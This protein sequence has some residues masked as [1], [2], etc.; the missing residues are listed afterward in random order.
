MSGP[1]LTDRLDRLLAGDRRALARVLT[2][3]EDGSP[4][5]LREI[6][7]AVHP[8]SGRARLIG[9]TGPPGVGKSTLVARLV[10][11]WRATGVRVAVLAVDPSS[12]FSGGALLGDRVRMQEHALDEGVFLRSMANRGHL[13][14]LAVAAPA[15]AMVLDAAGFETVVVETVGVGQAE[16]EV[17][18]LADTTVVVVAPGMGDAV[19]AGKAGLLEVADVLCVN[20]GD[21]DGAERTVQALRQQQQLAAAEWTSPIR[22]TTATTAAGVA[23]LAAAIE[24]HRRWLVQGHRL[25][26]RRMHRAAGQ[27]QE[28]A[29][30][31]VRDGLRGQQDRE[32]LSTLAEQVVAGRLDPYRAADALL[33]GAGLWPGR[34]PSGHDMPAR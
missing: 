17:A 18:A 19:Q 13:G 29:L 5:Q 7:A 12:P 31:E 20:Q 30:A 32:R 23:E 3:V 24:D 8:H 9:L 16:V 14:G 11:H 4:G 26:L 34:R 6:V 28:L 27:I 10:G 25:R 15:A 21:R 2:L 22:V 33:E 1:D